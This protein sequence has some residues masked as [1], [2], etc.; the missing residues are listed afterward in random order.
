V[1]ARNYRYMGDET[2]AVLASSV[3]DEA[4]ARD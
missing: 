2:Q 1:D 3:V 4:G